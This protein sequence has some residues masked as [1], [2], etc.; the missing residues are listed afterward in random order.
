MTIN[1]KKRHIQITKHKDKLPLTVKHRKQ[2]FYALVQKGSSIV[3]EV[4][5][6]KFHIKQLPIDPHKKNKLG[7]D[8]CQ[9]KVREE[10]EE[11]FSRTHRRVAYHYIKKKKRSLRRLKTSPLGHEFT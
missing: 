3:L 6:F 10:Y 7:N 11:F 5:L 1:K 9:A 8:L 4:I 2:K